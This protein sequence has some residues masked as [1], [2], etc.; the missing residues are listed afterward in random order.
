MNASLPIYMYLL[1]QTSECVFTETH[2]STLPNI[3][4]RLYR[5][6]REVLHMN[7]S[8]RRHA[9]TTE[10]TDTHASTL[11]NPWMS[12]VTQHRWM[13]HHTYVKESRRSHAVMTQSCQTYY[14]CTSHP[15]SQKQDTACI[16]N[17]MFGTCL[18]HQHMF[19]I[20]FFGQSIDDVRRTHE[21]VEPDLSSI[22]RDT[23]NM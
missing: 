9:N 16:I 13:G 6:H 14:R 23:G 20:D 8:P 15:K 22:H 2:V 7:Q 11:W 10:T 5:Y 4:T 19:G 1:Y 21:W 12:R 18:A 3:C 17:H